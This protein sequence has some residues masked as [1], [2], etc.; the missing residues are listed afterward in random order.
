MDSNNQN[1]VTTK[2]YG[3]PSGAKSIGT[4]QEDSLLPSSLKP[5]G[6]S[7]LQ[8]DIFPE[9]KDESQKILGNYIKELK[10]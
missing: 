7:I 2:E 1:P 5:K 10:S 9:P 6:K 3:S 8:E 4:N